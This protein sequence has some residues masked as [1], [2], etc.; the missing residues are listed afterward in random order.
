MKRYLLSC[1][2]CGIVTV[3]AFAV[4]PPNTGGADNAP[5]TQAPLPIPQEGQSQQPAAP[6]QQQIVVIP[7]RTL[8]AVE[9][10]REKHDSWQTAADRAVAR[11]ASPQLKNNVNRQLAKVAPA[12]AG[13]L[14]HQP[15]QSAIV[16]IA[17]YKNRQ[18]GQE[19]AA[20]VAFEGVGDQLN[21]SFYPRVLADLP[22]LPNAQQNQ[23][24][25]LQLDL[26]ATSYLCF[27]LDHADLKAGNITQKEMKESLATAI[28]HARA[29]ANNGEN[30]T[31]GPLV[32]QG[33]Q[34]LQA[35][36]AAQQAQAAQ[37]SAAANAQS[38]AASAEESQT[39]ADSQDQNFASP[40]WTQ[41]NPYYGTDGWIPWYTYIPG[42][43][44]QAID[45][46]PDYRRYRHDRDG[47][48]D[49]HRDHDRD[50]D[51]SASTAGAKMSG[52]T[53]VPDRPVSGSSPTGAR[54]ISPGPI[55]R[56]EPGHPEPTRPEPTRPEPT[57]PEPTHPEPRPIHPDSPITE[58]GRPLPNRPAPGPAPSEPRP[59]P[60]PAPH[61]EPAPA[62]HSE[63]A[64][65]PH[66]VPAPAPAPARK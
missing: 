28:Q 40:Y 24:D 16:T 52:V 38:S 27:F 20:A 17:V 48:H 29:E 63:P 5:G 6:M 33:A 12:V 11:I 32:E 46:Q 45:V 49:G 1:V 7:L 4:D 59:E 55:L 21:P 44:Q 50:G 22:R 57:H 9:S 64:P 34:A 62:P 14:L 53:A 2:V 23:T 58:P 3:P 65:A 10:V 31:G 51:A 61:P 30:A 26:E 66:S 36:Q 43:G 56:P 35:Q 15:G 13:A 54:P 39:A 60:A 25:S 18:S 37:Q 47:D 8:P 42:Y 19:A 41:A